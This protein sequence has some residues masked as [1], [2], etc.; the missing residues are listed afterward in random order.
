ML[1]AIDK[2]VILFANEQECH[3]LNYDFHID[4]VSTANF[5]QIVLCCLGNGQ[6]HGSFINGIPAFDL[7]VDDEDV[8]DTE[9][10]F[11]GIHELENSYYLMCSSGALYVLD[12]MSELPN[13]SQQVD[14]GDGTL[15]YDDTLLSSVEIRLVYRPISK[16]FQVSAFTV[17]NTAIQ[18]RGKSNTVVVVVFCDSDSVYTVS[19]N[20]GK[21][22]CKVRLP[23]A[24]GKIKKII[25]LKNYVLLL[26]CEG[27][28]FDFCPETKLIEK[29]PAQ[30]PIDDITVLENNLVDGI[31][32]MALT[33]PDSSKKKTMKILN[34]PEMKSSYALTI[35][36]HCWL[37]TQPKSALNMYYL[38]GSVSG[39]QNPDEIEMKKVS[40]LHPNQRFKKLISRGLFDEAEQF[41]MEFGLSLELIHEHRV[42]AIVK[43]I[44]QERN[45]E[46][47]NLAFQ[48]LIQAI[49]KVKDLKFLANLNRINIPSRKL[50]ETFLNYLSEK[51][52]ASHFE[53]KNVLNDI[54][55]Q[56]RRLDTLHLID[57]YECNVD[58][59]NFLDN[60]ILVKKLMASGI[61]VASLIWSR[62]SSSIVPYLTTP[63][64]TRIL[65][66]IPEDT[67][68]IELLHW[69]RHISRGLVEVHP[70]S[71]EV[72]VEWGLQK[73]KTLESSSL[74]PANGLQFLRN[75]YTT[76][77]GLE[78]LVL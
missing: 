52:V 14:C 75:M 7:S 68:F 39:N 18:F 33:R 74:W 24:C 71:L 53:E 17:F 29:R 12:N 43:R 10:T 15:V 41:A 16:P 78:F 65:A 38:N 61:Q 5:G 55:E 47:L 6:V 64:L 31:E 58:W 45:L 11:I 42:H 8:R 25:N 76:F 56:L 54:E 37:V 9:R 46:S 59:Q 4:C 23:K 67:E 44:R 70:H 62:H 32:M 66:S 28:L 19:I 30:D 26:N 22:P 27:Y 2:N 40:E 20:G 21:I 1:V 73:T 49:E 63:E 72:L 69:L 50:M 13:Q 3:V 35:S 77:K 60:Q 51:L 57:P 48:D 36:E 34:F